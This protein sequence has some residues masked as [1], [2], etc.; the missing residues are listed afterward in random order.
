VSI[1]TL[2]HEVR[3]WP[4]RRR[5]WPWRIGLAAL[6][7]NLHLF[8]ASG[9]VRAQPERYELG[10]R[11]RQFESA[12]E[13]TTDTARRQEA[14][15][16]IDAAV[17]SFFA[18]RLGEA[19][20]LVTRAQ[21]ALEE[22]PQPDARTA[23]AEALYL[24]LERRLLERS[25]AAIPIKLAPLYRLEGEVPAG[26]TLTVS[27]TAADQARTTVSEPI[28]QLPF[29]ATVQAAPWVADADGQLTYTLSADGRPLAQGTLGLA[30]AGDL[31]RRL[32]RLRAA[33]EQLPEARTTDRLTLRWLV[34]MLTSL[35]RPST[36]ETDL[37]AARLLAEAEGLAAALQAGRPYYGRQTAG[38]HWLAVPTGET[39]TLVRLQLPARPA[40]ATEPGPTGTAAPVVIALHGAGGSENMFFDT[41]GNGLI[42][43]LAA[44]RGWLVVAPRSTGLLAE[45][46][47]L[48][49]ELARLF[50]IDA[51]RVF[52][53]GHSMG[54]AQA[55]A[56]AVKTPD[57]LAAVAVL[58]GGQRYQISDGM[59]KLPIYVGVG[60]KDFAYRPVVRMKEGLVQAGLARVVYREYPGIEH[61]TI[62]QVALPEVFRFFDAV[63]AG[64][65]LQPEPNSGPVKTG[66]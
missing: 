20:R 41:Y 37:P 14:T 15:R 58:G 54:A 36:P 25:R 53:V 29:A 28:T 19:G 23:W 26:L 51:Q 49:D 11:L 43:R 63:A 38:Q 6:V 17:R 52:V 57:R 34:S 16:H 18:F 13:Q 64:R 45:I 27:I 21:A 22:R 8:A 48:V 44:Q 24:T 46:G 1:T 60:D 40:G 7:L 39:R 66:R 32:A 33:D 4:A 30:L 50:P 59:K 31:E 2:S 35:A 56:A 9:V 65:P 62:V 61:L 42:A 3:G 55:L 10:R 5:P 12:W 47:P